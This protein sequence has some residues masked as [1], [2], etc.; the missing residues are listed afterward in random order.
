M[1]SEFGSVRL[2]VRLQGKVSEMNFL[3]FFLPDVRWP[4]SKKNDEAWYLKKRPVESE[5]PKMFQ[6]WPQ[7]FSF[8]GFN[9]NLIHS[10]V[11]SQQNDMTDFIYFLPKKLA[12]SITM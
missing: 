3:G 9:K 5:G 1:S 10:C 6:K 4:E 8:S 7:K 12:D 2:S 11:K